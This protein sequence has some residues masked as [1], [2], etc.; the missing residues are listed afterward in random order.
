MTKL[1]KGEYT[2]QLVKTQYGYHIIMM[3][4]VRD[5]Q[6]PEFDQIKDKLQQQL[7]AQKRDKVIAD[8]RAAA[9][10]E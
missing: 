8:L 5:M 2:G 1:K 3:D 10:V 7:L 9:K 6:F 4:D